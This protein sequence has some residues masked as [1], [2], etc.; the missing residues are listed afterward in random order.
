MSNLQ[1]KRIILG[2]T[3]S[4]ATYKAAN[5]AST[6][7]QLGAQVD[8]IMT[9]AATHFVAPLTFQA[10][11]GRP[12]YTSMWEPGSG[13][14]MGAHI[15]HIG[16][17]HT[18]DLLLIAPA[19][20][21]T[22]AKIA[23][24]LAD[25]LLSV[26]ALAARCPILMAPAMDAG[27]YEAPVTQANVATLRERS[28]H[29]AGPTHGRMASGL[30]GRGRF[31]EPDEI[32]GHTRRVLGFDGPLAGRRIVVSAGPTREPFDPVRFIS[33]RSSG[34]QG[35]AIAQAAIDA[36]A[37][38]TLISGPVSLPTPVGAERIDVTT[39][40]EMEQAVLAHAAGAM[41]AD[42]LIMAAAV[43]DF[44]PETAASQKIKKIDDRSLTLSLAHNPDILVSVSQQDQRPR[45][46][47]G[48]AAES[49]DLV[50]NAQD[51]LVRKK[52]DLIVA[53]DIAASD[54]GFAVDTNRVIFITADG[55]EKLPLVSKET[56]AARLMVWIVDRLAG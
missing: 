10:L 28:V 3:G 14:G 37:Q 47:I 44:R 13:E 49:Q 55:I 45:L 5:I 46:T 19:T 7:T 24:G 42:A 43:G 31:L 30:E 33:N 2:V 50:A 29:F 25:D 41:S 39:A 9:E 56:V 32:V 26:T 36:G 27:M 1:D 34:K 51:K 52:L 20:A 15:A 22:I 4:I 35:F 18:A 11:T 21:N 53:N 40:S 6:L 12:V 38:V 8:V 17:G 23:H 48:F 54:A 16:L